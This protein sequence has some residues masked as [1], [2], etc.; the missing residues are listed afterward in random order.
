[1]DKLK[2]L[3]G[4]ALIAAA[5]WYYWP[6]ITVPAALGVLGWALAGVLLTWAIYFVK[7]K[8]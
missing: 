5:C 3:P 2:M 8:N 4:L 7:S 6:I 1:M